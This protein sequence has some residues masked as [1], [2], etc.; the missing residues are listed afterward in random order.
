MDFLQATALRA[1]DAG[2]ARASTCAAAA[3][4]WSELALALAMASHPRLGASVVSSVCKVASSPDLLLAIFKE[5]PLVVPDDAPTLCSALRKAAPWQRIMLGSGEFLASSP[6]AD[7]PGSSVLRISAPV[8]ISGEG[9]ARTVVR[10]TL[11]FESSCAGASLSNLRI[12]DGGDCCIRCHG[13][14]Y[15]LTRL[16]LRCSHGSALLADGASRVTLEDCVLGGESEHEIGRNVMISAYGSLQLQGGA[17]RACYGLVVREEASVLAR[18]CALR[19]CSE[20]AVL[21]AHRGRIQLWGCGLSGCPAA[22][23]MAGQG[24][25]RLLELVGCTL[26]GIARRR[27]WADEDRPRAF[28]WGEGNH[29]VR[30]PFGQ[31]R[32]G[33]GEG[34]GTG[35]RGGGDGSRDDC[36][37]EAAVEEDE[38]D[39]E[40]DD[41]DE[42]DDEAEESARMSLLPPHERRGAGSDDSDSDSL[43]EEEFADME[44][45]M[46]ELDD[47]ALQEAQMHT[48]QR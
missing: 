46:A 12:D 34:G 26:E 17:K 44:R 43:E 19:E 28:V 40:E 27:L 2:L 3:G 16:R 30:R 1:A 31:R 38:D 39:G 9:E 10:G 41:G 25:G 23:F 24:R 14:R 48:Q 47:A 35:G 6:D 11:I 8:H 29:L 18:T 36:E 37:E 21:L 42:E 32:R 45:L 22:A 4:G 13:G 20:A 15:E 7:H 5:I 33:G